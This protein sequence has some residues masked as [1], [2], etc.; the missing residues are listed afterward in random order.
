LD[1]IFETL[2]AERPTAV[3]GATYFGE[4]AGIQFALEELTIGLLP[5]LGGATEPLVLLVC[6]GRRAM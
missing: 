6:G 3:Y 1:L 2:A 5:F 4:L